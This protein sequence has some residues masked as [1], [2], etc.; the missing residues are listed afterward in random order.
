MP[1]VSLLGSL[2]V[3]ALIPG[4]ETGVGP[5]PNDHKDPNPAAPSMPLTQAQNPLTILALDSR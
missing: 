5:R 1:P 2:A 4:E 3:V